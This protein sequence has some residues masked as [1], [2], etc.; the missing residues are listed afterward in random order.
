MESPEEYRLDVVNL[1]VKLKDREGHHFS[2]S[3]T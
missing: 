2:D 3:R 1:T